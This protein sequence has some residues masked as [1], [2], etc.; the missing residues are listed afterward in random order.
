M[1]SEYRIALWK[2]IM[3]TDKTW[4]VNKQ[5]FSLPAINNKIKRTKCNKLIKFKQ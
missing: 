1:L 3:I 2:S 5:R 4:D